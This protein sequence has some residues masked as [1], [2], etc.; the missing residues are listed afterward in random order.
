MKSPVSTYRLQVNADFNFAAVRSLIDYFRD[1]G[2]GTLYFSPVF[3]ARPRSPHGYDVT[4]PSKF[5]GDVGD[6]A[7]F[8][9]LSRAT[10]AAGMNILLDIVPNHMAAAEDNPWWFD[11][12]EH[13]RA[14]TSAEFFDIDWD[15]PHARQQLILPILG[16]EIEECI[17]KGEIKLEL[18]ND[19][20]RL[21]Y[22]AR[23]L[24]LDPRSYGIFLQNLEGAAELVR[25]AN[26]IAERQSAEMSVRQERKR[27]S[28]ELKRA[29]RDKLGQ[30]DFRV[31]LE[32][33]LQTINQSEAQLTALLAAQAYRLEFWRSGMK[34]INY[35]RFF[36]ISDLAGVRIEDRDVFEVTHTLTL[37]LIFAGLIEGV[38]IDHVDGLRDPLAYL[39]RL[40][41]AIG[42][43][44]VVV[45]KILAPGED[46]RA[47]WPVQGTTGYDFIGMNSGLFAHPDGLNALT[48]DYSRRTRL[49]S[50]SDIVYE[51]KKFV[52]DA[53]F[54]GESARLAHAL[55]SL[56]QHLGSPCAA[57]LVR[58]ALIEV[59]AS[60]S[61]YRTYIRDH[62]A[63]EDRG[64]I[65]QALTAARHRAP[66]ISDATY[67]CLRRI[68]LLEDVPDE[69]MPACL[70]F[71]ID[72]QQF[73]GPVMAKG[74]ED[75]GF[76]TYHRLIS[77]SE[78][79]SHPDAL[80]TSV[81]Q[82]HETAARRAGRWP[83][84]MN[85]S[86]THDTKRS[87]D[88]R[89]RIA[90][91]SEM[92][93][94]W[95]AALDRWTTMNAASKRNVSGIRVPDI[96]DEILIYQTLLGVWPLEA[97]DVDGLG[98]RMQKFLVK[99]AREAKN[100]SSWLEPNESYEQALF[101]FTDTL[102]KD[103]KFLDDFLPMQREIA[104]YGAL[105]SLS[106]LVIKLGAPG[107]PDIY[108]GNELW[109][110]S[111]VDPDNRRPVDFA[112]RRR[113]L[114]QMIDDAAQG[115]TFA[116]ELMS[117][118][119][120]GRI[121]LYLTWI[122]LQLRRQ[123]PGLLLNGEYIPLLARG[124]QE[125]HV[126]AFARRYESRYVLFAAARFYRYL[127]QPETLPAGMSWSETRLQL[128]PDFPHNWQNILTNESAEGDSLT[129]FFSTLPFG[130]YV[131]R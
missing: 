29:L 35:R 48:E 41:E 31:Q 98:P 83:F 126:V 25:A 99:A 53:L 9:A 21:V 26:T 85:A 67:G 56:L 90:V 73:T 2:I 36:D 54:A 104:F 45:E 89:A 15:A 93:P 37:E 13:G 95:S 86:S 3:R 103:R 122:G 111:L 44:Y 51:K 16:S 18:R 5:S 129:S 52:I 46:L 115:R 82:F 127:T 123:N 112:L 27:A 91:L 81:A 80:E 71:I 121:K 109:N 114:Q 110:F 40:R 102:L 58:D 49:P 79:G 120:D 32:S 74:L 14:A 94:E 55:E 22:F 106:Q 10:A 116:Q 124:P 113:L 87:E 1:L 118:W 88:V 39:T 64:A 23:A 63:P 96:N 7:E 19:D 101:A 77:L 34:R 69:Y 105:N 68:L 30:P 33:A 6:E 75:T 11:L 92:A 17:R 70:E 8:G 62:V 125:E 12:L 119:Q 97:A 43:T 78:V 128:P 84:T 100:H 60:L 47:D 38:R 65:K 50:F 4:D 20:V 117:S 76:Y 131:A 107:V 57:G 59:S 130:I 66:H 61:V 24:P 42:E 72:W 108:Q 28:H